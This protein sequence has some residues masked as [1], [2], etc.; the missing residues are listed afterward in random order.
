MNYNMQDCK[1]INEFTI[2]CLLSKFNNDLNT[3]NKHW[4]NSN[5][6]EEFKENILNDEKLMNTQ[7]YAEL[8]KETKGHWYRVRA[9]FGDKCFKTYSDAGS[10]RIKMGDNYILISNNYGDGITRCAVFD[11][12]KEFNG[13]MMDYSGTVI[14]GKFSICTYDTNSDYIEIELNG[15]YEI[16]IYSGLVA[17]VK[18]DKP[19]DCYK[20]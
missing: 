7:G 4:K 19:N 5:T 12:E 2:K 11:D 3:V 18:F 9:M 16:Y 6:I 10:V 1:E 13:N 8:S 17:F 14:N 20:N 15:Y